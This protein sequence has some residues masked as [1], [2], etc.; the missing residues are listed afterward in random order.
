MWNINDIVIKNLSNL[1]FVYN[2]V[3]ILFVGV[4]WIYI[5]RGPAQDVTFFYKPSHFSELQ[6]CKSIVSTDFPFVFIFK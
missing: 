5:R 1:N 4:Y 6:S 2:A 3:Y